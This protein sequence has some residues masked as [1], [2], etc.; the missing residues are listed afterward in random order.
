M[1]RIVA[2]RKNRTIWA[3][4]VAPA[5]TR[6]HQVPWCRSLPSEPDSEYH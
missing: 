2:N 1:H 4:P 5:A 6:R 3:D